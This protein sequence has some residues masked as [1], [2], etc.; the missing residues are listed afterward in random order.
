VTIPALRSGLLAVF[1][2]AFFNSLTH[3]QSADSLATAA[4]N[5][6]EAKQWEQAGAIL[7]RVYDGGSTNADVYH[8]YLTAL[9]G[10]KDYK[11]AERLVNDQRSRTNSPI[12]MIDLGHVYEASGKDVKAKEQYDAAIKSVNGD[13]MLAQQLAANFTAIGHDDY[14]IQVYERMRAIMQNPFLYSGPLSRLYAKMGDVPKAVD[15]LLS[16]GPSPFGGQ[17]DSKAQL[18]ELLGDDAA[19]LTLAQKAIIR[20]INLQP[21]NTYYADLLTWLYTQKGDWEGA[22]LQLQALDERTNA[23]GQG[24]LQFA[25]QAEKERQY[26]IAIKSLDAV[27]EMGSAKPYYSLA[28][29]QRLTMG[30]HRLKDNP[31]FTKADVASLEKEYETFFAEFPQYEASEI[32]RDFA[33]L[34]A[35]F[36]DNPRKG[37]EILRRAIAQPMASKE[38]TGKAKLQLGDYLILDGQIWEASLTYS[39][40]DKAFREDFLGE[41]ARF[42]NGRLAYYRGDFAWAQ[43]QLSALKAS[44]SELIANDA[45][46]LSVLITENTPDSNTAALLL[47]SK[48]D[49]LLFQNKDAAALK[50]LDSITAIYPK[51][52]LQDDVLMLRATLAQKRHEYPKALEYLAAI[53]RDYGKDVLGDDAVF[54]TAE[55]YERALKDSQKAREFYEQ[56]IMDYPGSTYVQIARNRLVALTAAA[57]S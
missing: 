37:M 39:Q 56:L 20:R 7:R 11:A 45:L 17:D 5:L 4:H 44:T 8:D 1:F 54:K 15:A 24:L 50:V 25:Q 36:N 28:K 51:H 31:A 40:V 47:F 12:L 3:A 43:L 46:Y 2:C 35:Q 23:G 34:E 49:L 48:A 52:P 41:D 57:H 18:L 55:I 38:F 33:E 13:E 10:Q 22:L 9:L 14:A 53:I 27:V 19:K 6:I 29:A 30:M 26:E 42:R 21:E 32:A 16:G